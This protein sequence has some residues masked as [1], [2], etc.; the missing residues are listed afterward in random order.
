MGVAVVE[1][2]MAVAVEAWSPEEVKAVAKGGVAD[3][4]EIVAMPCVMCWFGV[5]PTW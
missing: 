5:T 3:Q 1:V 2:V 4:L